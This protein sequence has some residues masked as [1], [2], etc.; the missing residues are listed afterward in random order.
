MSIQVPRSILFF[1]RIDPS[2]MFG[3]MTAEHRIVYCTR[4][5]S[6]FPTMDVPL[7]SSITLNGDIGDV[8][9]AQCNRSVVS[10]PQPPLLYHIIYE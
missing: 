7:E 1:S 9:S 6:T 3:Y 8:Y 2:V 4:L 5:R 10:V